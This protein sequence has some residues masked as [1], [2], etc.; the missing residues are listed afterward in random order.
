MSDVKMSLEWDLDDDGN[1]VVYLLAG[2]TELLALS[3]DKETILESFLSDVEDRE[4]LEEWTDF[5]FEM[6][7]IVEVIDMVVEDKEEL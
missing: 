3:L 1:I 7:R 4:S 5:A 2:E 6:K